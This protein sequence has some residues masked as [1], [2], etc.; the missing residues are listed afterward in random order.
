MKQ[1]KLLAT[2][3][4]ALFLAMPLLL[5]FTTKAGAAGPNEFEA[6]FSL[7]LD[8]NYCWDVIECGNFDAFL[9]LNGTF[10][11]GD[12]GSG[13]WNRNPVTKQLRLIFNGGCS[14]VYTGDQ[15]SQGAWSGTAKCKDGTPSTATWEGVIEGIGPE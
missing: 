1:T 7:R 6:K 4:L 9:Y 8:V 15:V 11:T 5:T 2:L 12:G 3:V 10:V 14:P 13:R